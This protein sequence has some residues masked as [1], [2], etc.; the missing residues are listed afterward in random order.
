[1]SI[2]LSSIALCVILY[3]LSLALPQRYRDVMTIISGGL[4]VGVILAGLF[5]G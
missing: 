2:Y 1:M 3:L 5:V 4:L